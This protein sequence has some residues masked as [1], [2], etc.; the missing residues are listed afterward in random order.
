LLTITTMNGMS[1]QV[2]NSMSCGRARSQRQPSATPCQRPGFAAATAGPAGAG[3][4]AP[5]AWRGRAGGLQREARGIGRGVD[6]QDRPERDAFDQNAAEAARDH[7]RR[8]ALDFQ[9]ADERLIVRAVENLLDER[10]LRRVVQR[11]VAHAAKIDRHELPGG[12]AAEG[13]AEPGHRGGGQ[14][15]PRFARQQGGLARVAVEPRAVGGHEGEQHE[16]RRQ[17]RPPVRLAAARPVHEQPRHGE[18]RDARA[19]RAEGVGQQQ[20]LDARV[21]EQNFHLA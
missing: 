18:N 10:E 19:D 5:G 3:G 7:H 9:Q 15:S 12:E 1:E 6:Q 20:A 11:V 4:G 16:R 8:L 13:E 2:K 14:K 21:A 17:G